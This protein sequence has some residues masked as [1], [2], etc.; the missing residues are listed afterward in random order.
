LDADALLTECNQDPRT[1]DAL[2]ADMEPAHFRLPVLLRKYFAQNARII[3]FNVDPNFS[4]ALD[5]FM[6][7]KATDLSVPA[8]D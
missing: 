7:C 1:L 2:I 3:G 5:G 6:V 8:G 4:N